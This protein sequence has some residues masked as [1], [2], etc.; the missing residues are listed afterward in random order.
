MK[1]GIEAVKAADTHVKNKPRGGKKT[2]TNSL[3]TLCADR[4]L[5][6]S[7]ERLLAILTDGAPTVWLAGANLTRLRGGKGPGLESKGRRA[8][9]SRATFVSQ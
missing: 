9:E 8:R 2:R 1:P 3:P 6:A 4:W 5:F 7:I